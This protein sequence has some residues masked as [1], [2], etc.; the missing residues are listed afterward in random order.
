MVESC[1]KNTQVHNSLLQ[2]IVE[3]GWLA[4]AILSML[5]LLALR[6]ARRASRSSQEAKFVLCG[7]FFVI[8]MTMAHGHVSYDALLFLFLGYSAGLRELRVK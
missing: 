7:L 2:T 5:F 4:G 6:A 1:I 3:F 8:C